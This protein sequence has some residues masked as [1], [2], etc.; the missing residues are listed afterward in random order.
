METKKSPKADLESKKNIFFE[1]GLLVAIAVVFAAFEWKTGYTETSD[2]ITVS[3]EPEE[4]VM[5]PITQNL[6]QLPPPP[7]PPPSLLTLS[8]IDIDEDIFF[9]SEVELTYPEA[10]PGNVPSSFVGN[11]NNYN[12]EE[13]DEVIP[14][15]PAEDM[16]QFNGDLKQW[17]RKN[18]NYPPLA[19]EMN[20]QGKVFVQFVVEKDG[21]ISNVKVMRGV[22]GSLDQEAVRVIESM[23]KW[24]PGKQR[25]KPVR[26]AYNMPI[27]FEL[28]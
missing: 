24:I 23:P 21:S 2:F 17:L 16:P 13:T 15:V 26:V 1:I 10:I 25:G 3:W 4:E 14:F 27:I 8:L 7:P 19:A 5:I 12:D 22:D 28:R 9:E 20:I 18:L 6:S 11:L